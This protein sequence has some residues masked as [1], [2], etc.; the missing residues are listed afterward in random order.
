M[1]WARRRWICRCRRRPRNT[2]ACTPC[3]RSAPTTA[4]WRPITAWSGGPASSPASRLQTERPRSDE[5]GQLLA[6]LRIQQGVDAAQRLDHRVAQLLGTLRAQ[7]GALGRPLLVKAVTCD[8]IC[9]RAHRAPMID[10][11]LRTLGLELV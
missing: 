8:C 10:R 11:G 2:G 6:L 1:S 4:W 5:V 7:R 9:E 3:D